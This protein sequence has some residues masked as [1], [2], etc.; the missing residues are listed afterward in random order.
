MAMHLLEGFV[1]AST[2]SRCRANHQL[3]LLNFQI[4]GPMQVALLNDGFGN[5]DALR[6]PDSDHACFQPLSSQIYDS[7]VIALAL[8]ARSTLVAV[9]IIPWRP[10]RPPNSAPSML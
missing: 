9:F 8:R 7:T 6:I 4:D 2:G 5:P 10:H 3:P 1:P